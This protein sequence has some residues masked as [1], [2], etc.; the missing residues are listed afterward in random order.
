MQENQ[1]MSETDQ[2]SMLIKR[3]YYRSCNRGCK[4]TDVFI[5][6]FAQAY[7]YSFNQTE[8]KEYEEIL[9]EPDADILDWVTGRKPR[10]EKYAESTVMDRL[11]TFTLPSPS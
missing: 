6:A 7:L 9:E 1:P 4:E 8:L 5:G 2:D 10:P 11:I 3:L